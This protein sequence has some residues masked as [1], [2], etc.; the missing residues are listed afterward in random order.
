MYFAEN[1]T[2]AWDDM[3]LEIARTIGCRESLEEATEDEVKRL[4]EVIGCAV[5][6]VPVQIA[7]RWVASDRKRIWTLTY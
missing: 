4:G 7:G 1:G 3:G 5:E 6:A 2:F